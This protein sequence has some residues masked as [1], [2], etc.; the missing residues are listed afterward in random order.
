MQQSSPS[1]SRQ[2]AAPRLGFVGLGNMGAALAM[3]L[4]G[5][6][7][8]VF[9]ADPKKSA[10][11]AGDDVA[12]AASLQELAADSDII[13]T[14]LPTSAVTEKVLFG[15][16]GLSAHLTAD[17]IIVDMT[18]GDPARSRDQAA[19]LAASAHPNHRC[20]SSQ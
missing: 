19:R 4:V 2:N 9:D 6:P 17:H 1:R 20:S 7:L 15:P 8:S 5:Q 13:F 12:V 3:R 10:A 16:T 18:S 11:F 14:C